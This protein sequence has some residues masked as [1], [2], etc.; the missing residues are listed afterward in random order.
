MRYK[1]ALSIG[2]SEGTI[3]CTYAILFDKS[4][5]KL[6]ALQRKHFEDHIPRNYL[7]NEGS[8]Y[9]DFWG[10][11][12]LIPYTGAGKE[13]VVLWDG[14][15]RTTDNT[16][17]GYLTIDFPLVEAVQYSAD[18][19]VP[20]KLLYE[21]KTYLLRTITSA[22]VVKKQYS[23]RWQKLY[24][25]INNADVVYVKPAA[26]NWQP[27]EIGGSTNIESKTTKIQKAKQ[28]LDQAKAILIAAGATNII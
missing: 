26:F 7:V 21:A 15:S 28:K 5:R 19:L 8:D 14:G 18:K 25:T 1:Q 3:Q 11:N 17:T 10:D 2:K 9:G 6:F 16:D 20:A 12:M 24:D 4:G 13:G 27:V 22:K 23:E